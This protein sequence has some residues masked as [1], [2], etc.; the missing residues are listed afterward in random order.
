MTQKTSKKRQGGKPTSATKGQARRKTLFKLSDG[1][2]VTSG[3]VTVQRRTYTP[4][5]RHCKACGIEFKP[6]SKA[7]KYCSDPC[8]AKAYRERKAAA[9]GDQPREVIV[10]ALVCPQCGLGFYAVK[11]KGAIF[12]SPTCRASGYKVRRSAAIAAL[13]AELGITQEDARDAI[14]ARGLANIAAELTARGWLYDYVAKSWVLPL[15]GQ[16]V[17]AR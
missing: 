6:T 16:Y 2:L 9:T 3:R 11:G 14:E 7:A 12:C 5:A 13:A 10:E 15:N 17:F 8:R 1:T 4:R